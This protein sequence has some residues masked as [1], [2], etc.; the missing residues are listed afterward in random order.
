MSPQLIVA[1]VERIRANQ[2]ATEIINELIVSGY[3]TEVA[4]LAYEE[5]LKQLNTSPYNAYAPGVVPTYNTAP[6]TKLISI[7]D[8]LSGTWHLAI[9]QKNILFKTIGVGLLFLIGVVALAGGLALYLG[10]GYFSYLFFGGYIVGILFL[11]L[12]YSFM[13]RAV[14]RRSE[15][16]SFKEHSSWVMRHCL[17]LLGAGI[18]MVGLI[19]AGYIFLIIPGI[20]LTIYLSMTINFVLDGKAQGVEALVLSSKYVYGR[21]WP[22]FGRLLVAGLAIGIFSSLVIIVGAFTLFLFP[23]FL[24]FSLFFS[25]FAMACAWILLYESL[26]ATGPAKALPVSDNGLR[27]FYQVTGIIG[28]FL[29]LGLMSWSLLDTFSTLFA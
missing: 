7:S 21:F 22:V 13:F 23:F 3:T 10:D 26:L 16:V 8:L 2:S 18:L 15:L 28:A 20:L 19:M 12:A 11:C 29:Y 17:T 6:T 25:Y 9:E 5:A 1:I 4:N 14:L 24:F 27:S